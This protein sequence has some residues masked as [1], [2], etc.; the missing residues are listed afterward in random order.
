M[1]KQE[2][3]WGMIVSI[4]ILIS[5]FFTWKNYQEY[6]EKQSCFE[7]SKS[8]KLGK[9]AREKELE[10]QKKFYLEK[11]KQKET[12]KENEIRM[13]PFF[14]V[15]E[16][17]QLFFNQM[18][19]HHLHLISIARLHFEEEMV[20]IPVIFEGTEKE[21]FLCLEELE[22]YSKSIF[23]S[24]DYVKLETLSSGVLK[25][26]LTFM[27]QVEE[28]E[29]DKFVYLSPKQNNGKDS[30]IKVGYRYVYF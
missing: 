6:K 2:I 19:K 11:K 24:Q 17:E 1:K 20:K 23:F 4:F 12:K 25:A 13:I 22:Q 14:H 18:R 27:I 10:L 7:K 16:F 5:Y 26:Q 21:I 8:W 30:Y 28:V 29:E 15:L 3:R 9:E